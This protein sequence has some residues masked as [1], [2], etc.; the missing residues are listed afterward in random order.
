M[1]QIPTALARPLILGLASLGL[2]FGGCATN[3]EKED[4]DQWQ[5]KKG[6]CYDLAFKSPK[7]SNLKDIHKCSK[8]Y[9]AYRNLS[10]TTPAE[11][12]QVI[13][14]LK[15]L[16]VKG[17]EEQAHTAKQ[18]LIRFKVRNIPERAGVAKK[19]TSDKK[20]VVQRRPKCNPPEPSKGD[21]KAAKKH[22][23]KGYKAYKKE[24]YDKALSYYEKMLEVAPGW[25]KSM[26]NAA[27]LY[28][29]TEQT[30]KAIEHLSC[31]RDL[32]TDDA[33]AAL[34][35]A[36]RDSDFVPIRDKSAE[37]KEITGYCKIKIGNGLGEM[38][39]DN[40]DNFVA[41]LEKIGYDVH[42]QKDAGSKYEHP[43]LWYRESNKT[44]AYL[45]M[46]LLGHPDTEAAPITWKDEEFDIIIAWGD[47]VKEGEDPPVR[48]PDPD[49]A[50][51]ALTDIQRKENEIVR[52][53]DE[54]T[55]KVD[56]TLD[57]PDRAASQAERMGKKVEDITDAPDKV[58]KKIK[59]IEKI[60]DKLPF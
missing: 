48:V 54:Y 4:N 58:E 33:L 17:D 1:M 14:A 6:N 10:L 52:K 3:V 2:V 28:A 12:E 42:T 7:T 40:V 24:D 56:R 49:D 45:F 11:R 50:E 60:G 34:R 16:Y 13:T 37:F 47:T 27:A 46:K 30:D 19:T 31:L 53:P 44:Q 36:R 22:F 57:A 25:H 20:V 55:R 39:E 5:T 43:M 41:S 59:D 9:L 26:Y 21:I 51:D 8:R 38:G 32:G 35:K 15:V 18:G 29:L 23:K